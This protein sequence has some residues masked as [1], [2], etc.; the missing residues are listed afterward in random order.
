MPK[1]EH[2]KEREKK[3]K[4][5]GGVQTGKKKRGVKKKPREYPMV[6]R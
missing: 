1:A 4:E 6:T 2:R 5:P 3:L